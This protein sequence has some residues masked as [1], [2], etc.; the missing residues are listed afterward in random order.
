[1]GECICRKMDDEPFNVNCSLLCVSLRNQYK[2]VGWGGVER[3]GKL[4]GF[5][6]DAP[7]GNLSPAW[8]GEGGIVLLPLAVTS[9]SPSG[10]Y[11]EFQMF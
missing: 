4:L 6:S 10:A 2:Y 5:Y 7:V 3:G 1:M 9:P 11:G 8:S